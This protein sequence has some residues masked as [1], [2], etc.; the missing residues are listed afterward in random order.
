MD[1]K[2]RFARISIEDSPGRKLYLAHTRLRQC[3]SHRF[4]EGGFDLSVEGW[5]FLSHLWRSDGLTQTE[6]GERMEKDRH[7][8]SRLVD[9]LEEHGYLRRRASRSDRRVRELALTA[10]GRAAQMPLM[11]IATGLLDD[12]FAELGSDELVRFVAT[13]DQIITRLERC[14]GHVRR[15][16]S[17]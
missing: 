12:V 15:R 4:K 17:N 9:F 10:K 1:R 5:V 11:R 7:F 13:L 8:T 2:S 6:V 14:E 16:A 3:L